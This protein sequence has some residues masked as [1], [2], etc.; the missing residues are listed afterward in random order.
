M[1]ALTFRPAVGAPLAV[2]FIAVEALEIDRTYQRSVETRAAQRLIGQIAAD[3][4][5]RLCVP[6]LV[7]NRDGRLFVIDG[8]HRLSA[9][10]L[11]GDIP[12]LPCAV[13][14]FA[15]A[16]E[17]AALFI[18]ANR[19]RRVVN[20]VDDFRAAVAG[21]DE[22]AITINRLVCE[23]GLTIA[24]TPNPH[25]FRPGDI[26]CV[27]GLHTALKHHGPAILSAV[28]TQMGEAFAGQK[29]TYGGVLVGGLLK[30]FASPPP[31]F[32]P[33]RLTEALKTETADEWGEHPLVEDERGGAQRS[34]ALRRAVLQAY[35]ELQLAEA[36]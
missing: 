36:A 26:A 2:Q 5:W 25:A 17:E 35:G 19:K 28:L 3:W 14:S 21:G 34:S 4:D 23:A 20:K 11:R 1:K 18:R 32:D 6:L 9:A 12:H 8:Q 31:D 29:M 27:S 10:K 7:S 16:G 33:D 15:S 30:I 22:Q 24:E 13:S